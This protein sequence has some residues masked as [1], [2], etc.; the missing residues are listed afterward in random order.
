MTFIS[1]ALKS[2]VVNNATFPKVPIF[3]MAS[4]W[5]H[6][7]ACINNIKQKFVQVT[8]YPHINKTYIYAPFVLEKYHMMNYFRIGKLSFNEKQMECVIMFCKCK[9]FPNH[10]VC[11]KLKFINAII[12]IHTLFQWGENLDFTFVAMFILLWILYCP[13]LFY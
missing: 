12:L 6:E 2:P 9:S 11:F 7:S 10:N 3:T 13:N 1:A 8:N 4:L 5:Q